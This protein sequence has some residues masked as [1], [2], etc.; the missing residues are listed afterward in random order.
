L[1]ATAISIVQDYSVKLF[2]ILQHVPNK[3]A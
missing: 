1:I 2:L 3:V